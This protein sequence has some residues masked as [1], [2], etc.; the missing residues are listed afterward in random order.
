MGWSE[1][2]SR[3]VIRVS[4][5]RTTQDADVDAFIAAWRSVAR[6]TRRLVA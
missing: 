4:F 2:T 5:G 6:A 3:E 1:A